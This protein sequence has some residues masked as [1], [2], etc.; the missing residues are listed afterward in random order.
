MNK[1]GW[2]VA[3]AT[4]VVV[5]FWINI[6][7]EHIKMMDECIEQGHKRFECINMVKE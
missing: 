7:I 4:L 2:I 3:L 5:L 1:I 6:F